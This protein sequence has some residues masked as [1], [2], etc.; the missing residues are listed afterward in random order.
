MSYNYNDEFDMEDILYDL[1]IEE[2][3]YDNH[4]SVNQ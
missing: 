3:E 1:D 2:T 4:T